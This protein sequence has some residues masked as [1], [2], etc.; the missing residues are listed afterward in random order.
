[1]T[2]RD[3]LKVNKK[4]YKYIVV[5]EIQEIPIED[6]IKLKNSAHRVVCSGD[7]NQ[8]IYLH[9]AT[10]T[11]LIK[12]M[13]PTILELTDIFRLT[14]AQCELAVSVA[15]RTKLT[16]GLKA[17]VNPESSIELA[18]AANEA[19]ECRWVYREAASRARPGRPS[20]VLLPT[21][22]LANQLCGEVAGLMG[23]HDQPMPVKRRGR[24]DYEGLNAFW[25]GRRVNLRFVDN[26]SPSLREADGEPFVFLLTYHN[27]KGLAFDNVLIPF[28]SE[29]TTIIRD[30]A[31]LESRLLFSACARSSRNLVL[32]YSG[33]RA[34]RLL[35]RIALD[36]IRTVRIPGPAADPA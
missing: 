1:M 17:A 33:E 31:D 24:C 15:P 4:T 30:N 35:G 19:D 2:Y 32:T 25:R 6:L 5:D 8:Q 3:F 12:V 29:E 7:F 27:A 36:R 23:L 34:H 16:K 11:E 26:A 10:E 18:R 28:L 14:K 22:R 13:D 21:Y 9:R 20:A